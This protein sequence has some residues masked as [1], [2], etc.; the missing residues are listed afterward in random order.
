MTIALYEAFRSIGVDDV[1][2]KAAAISVC[3]AIDAKYD[4]APYQR[5]TYNDLHLRR[6]DL[7]P[8][9]NELKI[10]FIK[11]MLTATSLSIIV[12]VVLCKWIF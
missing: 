2:A 6:T 5:L 7:K 12:C 4:M 11:W 8:F 10:D 3:E 9:L 1:K